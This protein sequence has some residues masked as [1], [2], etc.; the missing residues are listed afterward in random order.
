MQNEL[1]TQTKKT[2]DH[3]QQQKILLVQV[4][5]DVCGEK[6]EKME[7]DNHKVS[8]YA[9]LAGFE[10]GIFSWNPFSIPAFLND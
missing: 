1:D 5:C 2:T 9:P 6:V 10:I 3:Q 7:L 4:K 8:K